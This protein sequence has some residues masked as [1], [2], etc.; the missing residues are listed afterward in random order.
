[1]TDTIV[2]DVAEGETLDMAEYAQKA[3]TIRGTAYE[4]LGDQLVN[5]EKFI[6]DDL[7]LRQNRKKALLFQSTTRTVSRLR[8]V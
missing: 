2:K 4:T 8:A 6:A 5:G 7:D 1:M 3:A